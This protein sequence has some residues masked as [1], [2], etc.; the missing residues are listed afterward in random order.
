MNNNVSKSTLGAFLNPLSTFDREQLPY[1]FD[2][3]ILV[4]WWASTCGGSTEKLIL[5]RMK[6]VLQEIT[7]LKTLIN[8]WDSIL[9]DP[10]L[11]KLIL[12]RVREDLVGITDIKIM[13]MVGTHFF[14]QSVYTLIGT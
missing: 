11:D 3:R 14:R 12:T 7:N 13:I 1:I 10:V 5:A 9:R 6:E 8:L 2:M 4:D